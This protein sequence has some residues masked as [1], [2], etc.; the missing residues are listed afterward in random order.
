MT[1]KSDTVK[2]FE[3]DVTQAFVLI[4]GLL[5]LL[6]AIGVLEANSFTDTI[7]WIS[8]AYFLQFISNGELIK[9]VM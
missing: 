6:V 7:K 5:T 8:T 4:V 9:K 1:L 2:F 3:K